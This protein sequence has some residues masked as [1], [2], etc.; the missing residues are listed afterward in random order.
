MGDVGQAHVRHADRHRKDGEFAGIHHLTRH[1]ADEVLTATVGATGAHHDERDVILLG[2]VQNLL[3][4][5][6]F[7]HLG[8]N[9][10]L[11]Q[12]AGSDFVHEHFLELIHLLTGILLDGLEV[13]LGALIAVAAKGQRH[14]VALINVTV[15]QQ[16]LATAAAGIFHTQPDRLERILAEVHR[17]QDAALVAGRALGRLNNL[18]SLRQVTLTDA[19]PHTRAKHL[20]V[21]VDV[22]QLHLD[23]FFLKG[24]FQLHRTVKRVDG[25][26][27]QSIGVIAILVIHCCGEIKYQEFCSSISIAMSRI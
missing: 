26:S 2:I 10:H 8:F 23:T 25:D 4:G 19:D 13:V 15:Q 17:Q 9:L 24:I 3:L 27:D 1:T 16:D 11:G 14:R 5:D 18:E 22:V 6:A 12:L 20:L 21:E 7:G